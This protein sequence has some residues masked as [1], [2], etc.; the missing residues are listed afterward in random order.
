M[1]TDHQISILVDIASSG[2]AA[3]PPERLSDLVDLI[4]AGY[5]EGDEGNNLYRLTAKGQA[6]LDER[7]VGANES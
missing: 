6:V 1:L 5:V 3:L 7:G 2:G 4:A